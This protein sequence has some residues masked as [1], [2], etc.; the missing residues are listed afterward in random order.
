MMLYRAI[1]ICSVVLY[2]TVSHSGEE[3][4]F[5]LMPTVSRYYVNDPLGSTKPQ[6]NFTPLSAIGIFDFGRDS[7]IFAHIYSTSFTLRAS[8]SDIGQDVKVFGINGSYQMMLRLTR[9]FRPWVGL[10]L[11]YASESYT[12]RHRITSEGYLAPGSPYQSR[13]VDS[14]TGILNASNEWKLNRDWDIGIHLQVEEPVVSGAARVFRGGIY[15]V[16]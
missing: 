5:G 11:G 3:F 8:T 15:F 16:Y 7:R 9:G 14:Y 13:T 6:D 12:A 2:A 4:R 10:G 1:F